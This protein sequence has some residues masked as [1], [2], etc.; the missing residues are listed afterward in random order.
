MRVI[1]RDL[2]RRKRDRL[3]FGVAQADPAVFGFERFGEPGVGALL[4]HDFGRD[5]I[6]RM[7]K[8]HRVFGYQ[9]QSYWRDVGNLDSFWLANMELV[10]PSPALNLYDPRWPIWTFQEQSPPAKFVFD[11]NDRRGMALDS[12]I[13]GGC[14]ISG[15]AV[16]K[17]L[18]FSNVRVHSFSEIEQAVVLPDVEIQRHCKLRKVIV[19]R[20]C[21]IPEGT[22]IGYDKKQDV[23]NGFRVTAKGV[24]LVTREMLGQRVGGI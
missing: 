13:S 11:D 20:G 15:S 16:R 1:C 23:L 6:P 8:T 5:I 17:S 21:V 7:Y 14:I 19:D 12:M 3:P 24:T 10:E 18:L 9:Y 4:A 2:N 22:V